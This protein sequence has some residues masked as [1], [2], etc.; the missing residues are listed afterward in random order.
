MLAAYMPE[1]LIALGAGEKVNVKGVLSFS[2]PTDL[3]KLSGNNPYLKT[4]VETYAANHKSKTFEESCLEAS[5]ISYAPTAVPTLFIHG[6][7]DHNVPFAQSEEL[8]NALV[9]AKVP[10]KLIAVEGGEHF[11]GMRSRKLALQRG[12]WFLLNTP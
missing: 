3:A 5:P 7:S 11:L 8:C 4:Y 6:T 12:L 10:A 2:G 1:D 9:R